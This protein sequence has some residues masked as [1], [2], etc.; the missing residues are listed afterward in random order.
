MYEFKLRSNP[1]V[2]TKS[3]CDGYGKVLDIHKY[4]KWFNMFRNGDLFLKNK[5]RGHKQ[6]VLYIDVLE[7]IIKTN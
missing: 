5:P 6:S 2:V 3:M 7:A 1:I 4:Q